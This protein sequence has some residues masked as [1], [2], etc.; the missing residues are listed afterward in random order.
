MLPLVVKNGSK[1]CVSTSGDM[2]VP[3]SLTDEAYVTAWRAFENTGWSDIVGGRGDVKGAA[4][5]HRI[6]RVDGEVD[7]DLL[8]LSRIDLDM[9]QPRLERGRHADLCAQRSGQHRLH[10]HDH[11]IEIHSLDLH[12]LSAA[13]CQQL[14][15]QR[16]G[17][18]GGG[19]QLRDLRR[20]VAIL[21]NLAIADHDREQVVEI[22]RD[23]TGERPDSFHALDGLQVLLALLQITLRVYPFDFAGHT[24]GE[25][26]EKRYAFVRPV[27]RMPVRADDHCT[28]DLVADPNQRHRDVG[29]RLD[30]SQEA[31][32]SGKQL[33]KRLEKLTRFRFSNSA[34]G[35]P[36][37]ETS[38][39]VARRSVAPERNRVQ[40]FAAHDF[41]DH[42]DTCRRIRER[43][44]RRR[45]EG[46]PRLSW[47]RQRR[48]CEG[49]LRVRREWSSC[50]WLGPLANRHDSG[51]LHLFKTRTWVPIRVTRALTGT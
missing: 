11:A 50:S 32:P 42:R 47:S 23:M 34:H 16:A 38:M 22:V 36:A 21:Q 37:I 6:P 28:D 4:F 43:F 13:E 9:G 30:R 45:P 1:M 25:K 40:S 14:P 12:H 19:Q 29:R 18:L 51:D 5:R 41:G 48:R 20:G 24:S 33:L 3:V 44:P 27:V 2:P 49:S 46:R 31:D 39:A 10:L 17:A 15:G 26:L 7:E 35:V 8:E